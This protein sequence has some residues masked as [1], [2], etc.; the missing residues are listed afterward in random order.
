M[1][2]FVQF[3]ASILEGVI[4]LRKCSNAGF[5]WA[6]FENPLAF[7]VGLVLLLVT[8]VL[9]WALCQNGNRVHAANQN[10]FAYLVMY[11]VH[12]LF[13][14]SLTAV[15]EFLAIAWLQ[16][17]TDKSH[18]GFICMDESLKTKSDMYG[19]SHSLQ[20]KIIF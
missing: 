3:N 15:I 11:V 7:G 16:Q 4:S 20:K 19:C 6:L 17:S 8:S 13:G 9:Y 5:E 18:K 10:I 14:L 12:L 2:L 1:E